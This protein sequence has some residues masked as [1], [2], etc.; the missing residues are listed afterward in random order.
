MPRI[1]TRPSRRPGRQWSGTGRRVR[2]RTER[3]ERIAHE[4]IAA[5]RQLLHGSDT[6][7]DTHRRL[8]ADPI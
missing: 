8:N 3:D 7:R 1:D 6:T 4:T 5:L 2:P